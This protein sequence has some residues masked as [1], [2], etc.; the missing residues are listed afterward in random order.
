VIP[1]EEVFTHKVISPAQAEKLL[2][3]SKQVLP[4]DLVVAVSSG[5]TLVADSDPRPAILNIGKQLADA[6]SK[7]N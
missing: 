5:S 6:V 2:K 3:K 4:E 1:I 7:L